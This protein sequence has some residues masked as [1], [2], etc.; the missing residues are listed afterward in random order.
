MDDEQNISTGDYSQSE[1]QNI[2]YQS[3]SVLQLRLDTNPIIKQLEITLRGRITE[4]YQDEQGN[5]IEKER[6]LS[7]PRCNED[8]YQAIINFV[9]SILN[10]QGLQS[11]LANDQ[12][13]RDYVARVY[14]CFIDDLAENLYRWAIKEHDFPYITHTIMRSVEL[15]LTQPI[16]AG[17]RNSISASTTVRESSSQGQ[18]RG[19]FGGIFKK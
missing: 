2:D 19:L 9:A 14:H 4:A 1:S 5:I 6:I 17:T 8:G 10:G 13:Y 18:S 7:Q 15:I 11:N 16:G 12:S 3:A